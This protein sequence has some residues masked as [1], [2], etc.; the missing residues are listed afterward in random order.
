MLRTPPTSPSELAE[1]ISEIC[2]TGFF[3]PHWY[4]EAYP[5]V[6]QLG[7]DALEHF[8]QHGVYEGRAPGAKFDAWWY[9]E[10][11]PAVAAA[12][13]A[14]F[15]HYLNDGRAEGRLAAP[16]EWLFETARRTI[17]DLARLEPEL[18]AADHFVDLRRLPIMDGRPSRRFAAA[19]QGLIGSLP[20]LFPCVVMVPWLVRGGADLF[21]IQATRAL[22]ERHGADAIL[23]VV[24][25]S[26]ELEAQSWL[27]PG[28]AIRVLSSFG[29]NLDRE[30]R[31]HLV[32]L[33]IR[34]LRPQSVFQVNSRACWDAIKRRGAALS[35]M[36]RLFAAGFCRDYTDGG[37][38]VGYADTHL[39]DCLP[40]LQRVY[41]DNATF[42]EE[43]I[44]RFG[45]PPSM[46]SKLQVVKQ[47]VRTTAVPTARTTVKE[48]R[49][50]TVVWAGRFA[51]QKNVDLLMEIVSSS[52]FSFVVWG[53]GE[54]AEKE[55]LESFASTTPN[56]I[57]RGSYSSYSSL[58]VQD[59]DALLY[60]SLWDGLPNVLIETAAAGVP[61]AASDVG[62]VKELVTPETGWLVEDHENP[63]AY[64]RALDEIRTI[65]AEASRR[66]DRMLQLV[67]REHS[68]SSYLANMFEAPTPL[69]DH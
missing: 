32:E 8:A 24:T 50:F 45:I 40:F 31:T 2:G 23:L 17:A 4:L 59:Y 39:R 26:D 13:V 11:N 44:A 14:P 60:T 49:S 35:K 16:P 19:W 38:P 42:A 61:I 56:L 1:N 10:Q 22:A 67:R 66:R 41:L 37:M 48:P 63:R 57:I 47:P 29:P 30:E 53:W 33:L 43:L 18:A 52:E 69:E 36:T 54:E 64:L 21:A 62:G 20:Q 34:A 6:A 5:D 58:P 55:R 28:I 51:K 68:W 27:P 65:P 15:L 3:D 7:M 46:R 9:L 25:D 12:G